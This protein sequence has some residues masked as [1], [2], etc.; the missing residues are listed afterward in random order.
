MLV[1]DMQTSLMLFY[2]ISLLK[3]KKNGVSL[4]LVA[5]KSMVNCESVK[6]INPII[7]E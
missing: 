1:T 7:Q 2:A 6:K 5:Q 3:L 4:I